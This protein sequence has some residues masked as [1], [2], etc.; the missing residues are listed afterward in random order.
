MDFTANVK[1]KCIS[2]CISRMTKYVPSLFDTLKK[3]DN[4]LDNQPSKYSC[5]YLNYSFSSYSR[6]H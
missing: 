1:V 5:A 4:Y 3:G 6:Q 2:S